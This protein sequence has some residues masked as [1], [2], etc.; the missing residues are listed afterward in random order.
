M[1]YNPSPAGGFIEG[2]AG[3]IRGRTAIKLRGQELKEEKE[4]HAAN[5]RMSI[6]F[7]FFEMLKGNPEAQKNVVGEFIL[8]AFQY[9]SKQGSVP[10]SEE[11][12]TKI[13]GNIDLKNNSAKAFMDS[14]VKIFKGY[15]KGEISHK[16]T[17]D[18]FD[19]AVGTYEGELSGRQEDYLEKKRAQHVAEGRKKEIGALLRPGMGKEG[20]PGKPSPL[21]TGLTKAYGPE[22]AGGISAAAQAGIPLPKAAGIFPKKKAPAAPTTPMYKKKQLPDGS[23]QE[24]Q[25]DPKTRRHTIPFGEPKKA[26]EGHCFRLGH[27]YYQIKQG[28]P[29]LIQ[30][31]SIDEKAAM[32]SMKEFGWSMMNEADQIELFEKNKRLLGGTTKKPG[33]GIKLTR[34]IAITLLESA[35][36][37]KAEARKLAKEQGY[38][39]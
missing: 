7:K 39:F 14:A 11:R 13:F 27:N 30:E 37:D 19:A 20:K 12:M 1:N 18:V 32:M 3:G 34:E 16:D 35:G 4:T 25:F 8:P 10:Y 21:M 15:E 6:G 38:S 24:M 31:G 36:G 29:E 28:K 17:L 26:G 2:I 33:Q 5:M 9:F 22:A 23:V